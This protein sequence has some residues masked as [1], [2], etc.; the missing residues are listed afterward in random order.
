MCVC[1]RETDRDKERENEHDHADM[2][3]R[4][5]RFKKIRRKI[6]VEEDEL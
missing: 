1:E 5:K 4:H 3:Q 6:N 2:V